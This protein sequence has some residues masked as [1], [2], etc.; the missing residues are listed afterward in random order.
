MLS[1][2]LLINS[3]SHNFRHVLSVGE[4][5]RFC[6]QMHYVIWYKKKNLF[7][8]QPLGNK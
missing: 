7:D 8:L 3:Q 2:S 6:S 1:Q 5:K 4:Q